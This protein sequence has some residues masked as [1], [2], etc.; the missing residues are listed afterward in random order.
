MNVASGDLAFIPLGG[1]GEIGLNLNVYRCD[2][3]LLAVDMWNGAPSVVV[4]TGLPG[5]NRLRVLRQGDAYNGVALLS[6][7]PVAKTATFR[8]GTGRSFTLS[9]NDGG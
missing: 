5:D 9:V 1:T 3:Q 8:A 7:D 2:G 6:V 4:G